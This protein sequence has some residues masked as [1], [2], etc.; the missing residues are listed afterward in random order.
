VTLV[1]DLRLLVAAGTAEYSIAGTAYWSDAQLQAILDRNRRLLWGDPLDFLPQQDPG[2]V[3][4]Y[5]ALIP[6]AG[7][8]EPGALGGGGNIGTVVD[9]GGTAISGGTIS[10]T[11]ELL[12]GADQAG[13]ARFFRGYCYDLAAAA[14][15]VLETWASVQ[16][17][18]Y[19]FSTDDQS[20]SRSQIV[21]SLEAR[22]AAFR[23]QALPV[24]TQI[25]RA[26]MATST[27][28]ASVSAGRRSH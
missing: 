17:G 22:A 26:D 12:F 8:L 9:S 16:K 5:R 15:E 25:E 4:Y 24:Q 11:G 27:P 2:T 14:A 13:S 6:V 18:A 1:A 10:S 20:F 7:R 21:A 28:A 3:H 23:L 19:D